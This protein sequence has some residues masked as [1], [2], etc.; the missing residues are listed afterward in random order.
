MSRTAWLAF[1]LQDEICLW[2]WQIDLHQVE[3]TGTSHAPLGSRA[4]WT[5]LLHILET[6]LAYRRRRPFTPVM[7]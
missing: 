4:G 5:V 1:R 3:G 2:R 7:G 6:Q